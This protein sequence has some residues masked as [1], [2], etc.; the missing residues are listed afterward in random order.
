MDCID[1]GCD[2]F[3][4][5]L[6]LKDDHSR[7][8]KEGPWFMNGHYLS[9]NGWEPNFRP[10]VASLSIVAV[11]VRLPALPIEYYKPSVLQDIGKAIGPVLRIDTHT[12]SEARGRFARLCV[13]VNFDKPIIKIIKIGG[14]DQPVQYEGI[15]ALC[16]SCG[17]VGHKV[18]GCPY[19]LWKPETPVDGSA[20]GE[21]PKTHSPSKEIV[22]EPEALGPWVLVSRKKKLTKNQQ[23]DV[24]SHS[25]YGNTTHGP[26]RPISIPNPPVG[27]FSSSLAP[28][29]HPQSTFV[30][31]DNGTSADSTKGSPDSYKPMTKA[32]GAKG[33]STTHGQ[34]AKT[35]QTDQVGQKAQRQKIFPEWKAVQSKVSGTSC[36]GNETSF[37]VRNSGV[38]EL[39]EFRAGGS[40]SLEAKISINTADQSDASPE[41]FNPMGTTSM[42]LEIFRDTVAIDGD[43]KDSPTQNTRRSPLQEISSNHL[44]DGERQAAAMEFE[45]RNI[46]KAIL[47]YIDPTLRST[48]IGREEGRIQVERSDDAQRMDSM[49]TD[50]VM[51]P[52]RGE[53]GT[54]FSK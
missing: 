23:K 11:W 48:Y 44:P 27:F 33:K 34:I 36:T 32:S 38:M 3:L 28:K 25:H 46:T 35:P 14:I 17:C 54:T 43:P 10:E 40:L 31:G 50:K 22:A 13:Q 26:L 16:F 19:S 37:E 30:S 12:A 24:P 41:I 21:S 29:T 5:R 15:N 1:L 20:G 39:K 4:I 51:K 9:I 52:E 47:E 53:D 2:F 49:S 42:E 7:V 8:L 6:S 45:T 18:E